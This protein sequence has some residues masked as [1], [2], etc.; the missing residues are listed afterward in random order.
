MKNPYRRFGARPPASCVSRGLER[1]A[2]DAL[3]AR[4][5]AP[6]RSGDANPWPKA[7]S[8]VTVGAHALHHD[9]ATPLA[10]ALLHFGG[11]SALNRSSAGD[12]EA[13][14][15]RGQLWPATE[16]QLLPG[17]TS[18][19]H[20]NAC[21][22]WAARQDTLVLATGYCLDDDGLWRQ[23][24]WCVDVSGPRPAIVETTQRR[25]LY[26]GFALDADEAI[27]MCRSQLDWSPRLARAP[28]RAP[29]GAE[30]PAGP[31]P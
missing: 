28:I 25:L 11:A 15:C 4:R 21:L 8:K 2:L 13:I 29:E 19:C 17:R 22:L 6:V 10:R 31:R 27:A 23:H 20:D 24:S 16:A 7:L 1:E 3:V 12:A 9:K 26:F 30:P 5:G 18:A 14:A